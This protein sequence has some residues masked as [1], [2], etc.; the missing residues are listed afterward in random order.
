MSVTQVSPRI[1]ALWQQRMDSLKEYEVVRD[2]NAF[3]SGFSNNFV[4]SSEYDL[5]RMNLNRLTKQYENIPFTHVFSGNEITNDGGVC[6]HI[7]NDFDLPDMHFNSDRFR[8]DILSD[9]T[10]AKGIGI[11]KQRQ[12]KTHGY[13]TLVDLTHHPK[14]RAEA[15]RVIDCLSRGNSTDVMEFIGTRHRKSHPLALGT[16][17]FHDPEEYV[18]I[19]IETLGLFSRPITLFGVGTIEKGKLSVH[20]YLLRDIAEE[21]AALIATMDHLS[22]DHPA[23]VTF[24][25]KSFDLPYILDRLAFYN[26][27]SHAKVSHYDILHFSRARWKGQ[28]DSYR[29]STLEKAILGVERTEDIPGQ[30]VPEFYETYLRT[31]NCGPL[32]PVVEHNRQDVLSLALLF[33]HLLGESY[34]C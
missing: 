6:F 15:T 10:L 17:G 19:D 28:F 24:N 14:F 23:L 27:R 18:F 32:V 22:G 21:P 25:G 31:G 16:A 29:L 7:Q 30:M 11:R 4:F 9:L 8:S 26:L 20:Q 13:G 1:G 33:I 34:G 2:G 5:A 3:A 12:L